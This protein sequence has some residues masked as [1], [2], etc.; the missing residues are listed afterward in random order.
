M[1]QSGPVLEG[2]GPIVLCK[3]VLLCVREQPGVDNSS[4]VP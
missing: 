1:I 2:A 4:T 3:S